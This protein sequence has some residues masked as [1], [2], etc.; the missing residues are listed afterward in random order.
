MI[1]KKC[2]KRLWGVIMKKVEKQCLRGIA[3]VLYKAPSFLA[4]AKFKNLFLKR[5]IFT[6]IR[7]LQ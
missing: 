3:T 1:R 4:M 5:G 6:F 2:L 7:Y